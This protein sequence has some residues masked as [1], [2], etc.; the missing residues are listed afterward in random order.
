MPASRGARSVEIPRAVRTPMSARPVEVEGRGI[1]RSV[2]ELARSGAQEHDPIPPQ[3]EVEPWDWGET[4]EG[5][6][7]LMVERSATFTGVDTGAPST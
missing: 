2:A 1:R 4:D 7:V 5:E 6:P 3:A